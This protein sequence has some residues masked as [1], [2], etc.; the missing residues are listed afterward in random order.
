MYNYQ[1]DDCGAIHVVIGDGGNIEGPYRN[2]VDDIFPYT[3][4]TYCEILKGSSSS[5]LSSSTSYAGGL[6]SVPNFLPN[7][8]LAVKSNSYSPS[9]Q[10]ASQ[11]SWCP[12]MSFQPSNSVKGGPV[13]V[14]YSGPFNTTALNDTRNVYDPSKTYGF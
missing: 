3:N 7:D 13:V 12:T 6:F 1:R 14:P 11:P 8:T 5:Q 2:F 10:R 9:Y 4:T